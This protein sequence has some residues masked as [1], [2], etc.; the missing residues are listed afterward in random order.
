[1]PQQN[2]DSTVGTITLTIDQYALVEVDLTN[3]DANNPPTFKPDNS[4]LVTATFGDLNSGDTVGYLEIDPTGQTTGTTILRAFEEGEDDSDLTI[5]VAAVPPTVNFNP[6]NVTLGA[7]TP[8]AG[9]GAGLAA[10]EAKQQAGQTS[11]TGTT[12]V[13]GSGGITETGLGQ[14]TVMGGA[15]TILPAGSPGLPASV[16]ETTGGTAAATAA[17][18][19][20]TSDGQPNQV[21]VTG[22][23]V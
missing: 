12:S 6:A 14:S 3:Y 5:I 17:G 15:D 22:G 18:P 7:W 20:K 23:A 19:G 2:I 1:M 16:G 9:V 21:T 4:A 13:A 10:L 11:T 8:G